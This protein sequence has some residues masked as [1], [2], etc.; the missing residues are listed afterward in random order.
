M[1]FTRPGA[2]AARAGRAEYVALKRDV[3]RRSGDE[4]VTPGSLTAEAG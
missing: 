2:L 3:A 1:R 4:V